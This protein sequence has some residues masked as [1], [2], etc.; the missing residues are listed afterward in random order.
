MDFKVWEEIIQTT[1][2]LILPI[3]HPYRAVGFCKVTVEM[4]YHVDTACETRNNN[5]DDEASNNNDDDE[6]SS[7]RIWN[8]GVR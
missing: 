7:N 6:N 4:V 5:D 1:V 8:M 3:R 2:D